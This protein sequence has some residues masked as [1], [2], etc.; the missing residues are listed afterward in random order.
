M[1]QMVEAVIGKYTI[2]GVVDHIEHQQA[3]IQ[4]PMMSKNNM[5]LHEDQRHRQRSFE[6]A[7]IIWE[8]D[9]IIKQGPNI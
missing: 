7:K 8:P 5:K 4:I 1:E 3:I 2:Q 9:Q 6:E